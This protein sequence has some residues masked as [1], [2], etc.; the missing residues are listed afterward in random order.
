MFDSCVTNNFIV[1]CKGSRDSL[2][3]ASKNTDRNPVVAGR[4]L[5]CAFQYKRESCRARALEQQERA[6]AG[7]L[8]SVT[9]VLASASEACLCDACHNMVLGGAY[10]VLGS[11]E[12]LNGE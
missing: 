7:C 1:R 4:L 6:V 3:L 10:Q 12:C 11:R 2:R 5:S 8:F 9:N